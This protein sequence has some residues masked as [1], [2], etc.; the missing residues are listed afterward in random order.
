METNC[1]KCKYGPYYN[2]Y[3]DFCDGCMYDPDTGWGGFYD[4]RVDKHF[5][6]I[7]EQNKFYE[8]NVGK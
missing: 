2:P 7:E 8:D 5:N 3:S 6:N 4:H 1:K